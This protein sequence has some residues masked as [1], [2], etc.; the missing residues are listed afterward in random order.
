ME[1]RADVGVGRH[2]RCARAGPPDEACRHETHSAD[3]LG[4]GIGC[5]HELQA[6]YAVWRKC[7]RKT[8]RRRHRR[9]A[10]GNLR[11]RPDRAQAGFGSLSWGLHASHQQG[12]AKS[13]SPPKTPEGPPQ[14]PL[15]F[16]IDAFLLR[17]RYI[18]HFLSGVD[19]IGRA[20]CRQRRLRYDEASQGTSATP[21]A[22][23]YRSR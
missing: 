1:A 2:R 12:K 20:R 5:A 10:A 19:D 13:L 3:E 8:W 15:A 22:S 21:Q 11:S 9:C 23:T 6:Q 7:C 18:S 14:E 16:V 17:R 4:T